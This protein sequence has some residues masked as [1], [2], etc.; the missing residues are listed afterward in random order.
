M[1]IE[2]KP[3]PTVYP[4]VETDVSI[5]TYDVVTLEKTYKN[6]VNRVGCILY[7]LINN[8]IYLF[9]GQS[10]QGNLSDFGGG[11]KKT[12]NMYSC[13]NRET[14]EE[15]GDDKFK[16]IVF[17]SIKK[18]PKQCIF[19]EKDS[20]IKWKKHNTGF[21]RSVLFLIPVINHEPLVRNFQKNSE[22]ESVRWYRMN[23]ILSREGIRC[24]SPMLIEF[25]KH[26]MDMSVNK[27][28]KSSF[29]EK[30]MIQKYNSMKKAV[31][32]S[33]EK[34]KLGYNKTVLKSKD[35]IPIMNRMSLAR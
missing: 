19:L 35:I 8:Q 25:F 15:Y 18:Y 24:L 29:R 20:I 26:G 30:P 4:F 10:I 33:R 17:S 11:R 9:L 7:T 31:E 16:N 12:E 2:L 34:N 3:R 21:F 1:N 23:R 5:K 14:L 27:S 22:I 28:I 32:L 6:K 13:L